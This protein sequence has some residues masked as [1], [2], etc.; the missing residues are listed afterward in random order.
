MDLKQLA[1][2]VQVAETGSFTR[3]AMQLRVAQPALSRQ[4]R[5]LEVELRMPLFER[6]GR[7]VTLTD[8]GRRL[9]A[10]GRGILQQVDRARQDLEE[11]RGG[12]AG[13]LSIGM[14]PSLSRTLTAPLVDAFRHRFPKATLTIV[15]GLSSY[16]VEW[17]AQGRVDTALIYNAEPS[18]AL[19]LQPLLEMPMYLLS[20]RPEGG[21]LLGPPATLRQLAALELVIPSRP[22]GIRMR[23][24]AALA[25]QGLKPRVGLEIESVPAMLQL[26][27]RHA[28]HAVLSFDA[29]QGS[30]L[31]G[32]LQL[33]QIGQPPL[34]ATLWLAGSAQRPARALQRNAAELVRELLAD[35]PVRAPEAANAP[36]PRPR[37]RHPR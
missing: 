28:L 13:A 30:G 26:V 5:A 7:G 16:L 3:A 23:I 24:E 15:E 36:P 11:Q 34:T 35:Y 2:F 4:V 9:L 22:H 1:T 27:Q 10:H 12:A 32:Q 33:R 18:P 6:N 37:R 19:D 20:A 25:R 14:P 21:A 8:A 17:L 29:V 31:E